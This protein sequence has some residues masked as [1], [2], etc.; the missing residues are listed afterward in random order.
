[1]TAMAM[2]ASRTNEREENMKQAKKKEADGFWVSDE[3]RITEQC[4]AVYP[5]LYKLLRAVMWV[6]IAVWAVTLL[7]PTVLA[8]YVAS[9]AAWGHTFETVTLVLSA[10]MLVAYCVA[11]YFWQEKMKKFRKK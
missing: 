11:N 5:T 9:Y 4:R 7:C 8:K 1:M 2:T 3:R 10:V 6:T